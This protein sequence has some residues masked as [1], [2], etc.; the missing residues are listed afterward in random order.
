MFTP[1]GLKC[2]GV[3]F[4]VFL[5]EHQETIKRGQGGDFQVTTL[6]WDE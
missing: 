4:E 2:H 5:T 3:E 1:E 6:F